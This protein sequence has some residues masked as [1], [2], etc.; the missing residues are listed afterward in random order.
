MRTKTNKKPPMA[1]WPNYNY[2]E[3]VN[4]GHHDLLSP[5]M[6]GGPLVKFA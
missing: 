1:V 6:L 2:N 4:I 5:V 3:P